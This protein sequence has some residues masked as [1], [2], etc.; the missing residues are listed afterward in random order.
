MCMCLS[1]LAGFLAV[2]VRRVLSKFRSAVTIIYLANTVYISGT[3]FKSID[4]F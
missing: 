1:V 2:V 3:T 4:R